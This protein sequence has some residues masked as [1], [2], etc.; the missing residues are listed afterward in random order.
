ML[1][2]LFG[3]RLI[4]S[5]MVFMPRQG[6]LRLVFRLFSLMQGLPSIRLNNLETS[7]IFP[8][9]GLNP[10]NDYFSHP[11]YFLKQNIYWIFNFILR[12]FL[13]SSS[14]ILFIVLTCML[15]LPYACILNDW[16]L[17]RNLQ[18]HF[19]YITGCQFHILHEIYMATNTLSGWN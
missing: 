3:L 14:H 1:H 5:M 18:W 4:E 8:C 10:I 2:R 19:L 12:P 7:L 15:I 17:L 11:V 16:Q 13:W 9:R 6:N